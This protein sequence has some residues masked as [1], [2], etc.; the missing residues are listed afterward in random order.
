MLNASKFRRLLTTTAAFGVLAGML[1][2]YPTAE[3]QQNRIWYRT[4]YSGGGLA[5]MAEWDEVQGI[6]STSM[7]VRGLDGV[8]VIIRREGPDA[9]T[10]QLTM[11]DQ[12][13]ST[14]VDCSNPSMPR[15]ATLQYKRSGQELSLQV[16]LQCSSGRPAAADLGMAGH[17]PMI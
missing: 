13:T 1:F 4:V 7:S 2:V 5:N 8:T 12:A 6:G 15:R 14:A 3:A 11:G 10:I 9:A 16:A 17:G